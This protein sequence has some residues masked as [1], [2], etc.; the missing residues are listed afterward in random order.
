MP[1]TAGSSA[2][3]GTLAHAV[4]KLKL[5]KRFICGVSSQKFR[6]SMK[7]FGEEHARLAV[8]HGENAI[9]TWTEL[10][11]ATDEYL[12]AVNEIAK[13]YSSMPYMVLEKMVN[14]SR[15]VPDGF[16]TADVLVIGDDK[17]HV[18]DFKFG[19]GVAVEAEGNPQMRLYALGA[20]E[21]YRLIYGV[22]T[23]CMTIVQP[24]NGGVSHAEPMAV[25]AL[26]AWA[27]TYVKPR[28]AL[29]AKGEGDFAPGEWCRFCKAKAIC[30]A[31]GQ[32][33]GSD[34][35]ERH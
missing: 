19:R 24:R 1:D 31:R 22:D 26:L 12:E 11:R 25:P 21:R 9:G 3:A 4:A 28:A 34:R 10:E 18:V 30:R 15:W 29:A 7:H 13:A 35:N 5:R 27:E 14:F 8:E 33:R 20:L 17:L 32:V 2:A 6:A 16:G 23:V